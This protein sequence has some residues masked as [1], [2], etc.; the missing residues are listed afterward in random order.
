MRSILT[1]HGM[2]YSLLVFFNE[3]LLIFL[4]VWLSKSIF[5]IKL[6]TCLSQVVYWQYILKLS[7]ED[8]TFRR[9]R[10]PVPKGT[11]IRFTIDNSG[12]S[13]NSLSGI[14][15]SEFHRF[16]VFFCGKILIYFSPR[17]RLAQGCMRSCRLV[18]V[19]VDRFFFKSIFISICSTSRCACPVKKVDCY[20]DRLDVFHLVRDWSSTETLM[21]SRYKITVTVKEE[22][23]FDVWTTENHS[24]KR[25]VGTGWL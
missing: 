16:F 22:S 9:T 7:E 11:W 17:L 3:T 4:P 18:L 19:S 20:S 1:V 6:M 2:F 12:A 15:G 14:S 21:I 8:T 10:F 24:V 25:V 23:Q 5:A 13:L